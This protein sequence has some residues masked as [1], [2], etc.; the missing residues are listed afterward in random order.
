MGPEWKTIKIIRVGAA[1][2]TSPKP[3]NGWYNEAD[4][5]E[6][7]RVSLRPILL[8]IVA[9]LVL[10]ACGDST[11][12]PRPTA[13][14]DGV[15][16]TPMATLTT[17][18]PTPTT[19]VPDI[20]VTSEVVTRA[21]FPVTLAFAPDGRLFY[22]EFLSGDI[23][24]FADGQT[25]TFAH[26]DI[27][28]LGEC[29]LL[30][31]AI[32]PEFTKT[33][34]VYVYYVEPV[35]GRTDI[36]HPVIVR[37]T[38]VKGQGEDQTVIVGDLPN[39]NPIICGHVSGNIHFSPDGYLYFIIGEMEF[40]TP[41]QDLSSPLGKIHRIDKEAGSAAPDNPFVDVEGADPRVFAYGLRNSFD[42]TFSPKTGKIYATENGLGNCDELN[43]IEAGNNYGHPASSFEKETPPCLE[44]AGV[45]PIYL[46]SKEGKRP[47][48]FSSNAAPTGAHFVSA[49]AYPSLGDALLTCEWN[50]G[51][52]RR[53]VLGGPAQDKVLDD[54]IVVEDCQLDITTD[55]NGIV[56]YSNAREILRLVPSTGS[57]G[58]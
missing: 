53:L 32:D 29:G 14:S 47:E 30:G 11:E 17:T 10:T 8:I 37:F 46:Y 40:K 6:A 1:A 55:R 57:E 23:K 21:A 38:D 12:T 9:T 45:K 3:R 41:A 31:L 27:F 51:R 24:I 49:S 15:K 5:R 22:N 25:S 52:M 35:D 26:V 4:F 54:S 44:R 2:R 39:T 19:E 7:S 48:V 28:S 20:Q 50:T 33:H 42:F 13:T 18:P 56:Y 43:M 36:G 34:Y 58:Q 16:V